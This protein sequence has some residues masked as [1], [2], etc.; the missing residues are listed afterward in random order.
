MDGEFESLS[1]RLRRLI[2]PTKITL[3]VCVLDAI[4]VSLVCFISRADLFL[5]GHLLAIVLST[6]ITTTFLVMY[7]Q[8]IFRADSQPS[9]P[10]SLSNSS[11]FPPKPTVKVVT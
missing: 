8:R 1:A 7:L 4:A 10:T 2:V 5:F 3:T 6:S 9:P 11:T